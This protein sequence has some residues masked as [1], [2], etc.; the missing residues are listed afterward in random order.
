MSSVWGLVTNRENADILTPGTF[1]GGSRCE[2]QQ[3]GVAVDDAIVYGSLAGLRNWAQSILD[4]LPEDRGEDDPL[5]V[6]DPDRMAAWLRDSGTAVPGEEW[7]GNTETVYELVQAVAVDPAAA[8]WTLGGDVAGLWAGLADDVDG[9]TVGVH[10]AS[11]DQLIGIGEPMNEDDFTTDP[12]HLT[13]A[14]PEWEY[15]CLMAIADRINAAY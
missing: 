6:V 2:A 11:T 10:L 3:W 9:L 4:Q 15:G 14:G 5:V 8:G 13:P 12:D 1:A 7:P